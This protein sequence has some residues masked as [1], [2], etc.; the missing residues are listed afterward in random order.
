[1]QKFDETQPIP[2]SGYLSNVLRLWPYDL[3]DNE[4]GKPLS[5]FQRIRAKAEEELGVD[6]ETNEKSDGGDCG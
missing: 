6:K 1:M 5:K 3:P 2:F 4:L